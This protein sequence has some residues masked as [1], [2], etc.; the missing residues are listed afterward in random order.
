V[1]LY[2][3]AAETA[4]MGLLGATDAGDGRTAAVVM[5][6]RR[7][8]W[9]VQLSLTWLVRA[10]THRTRSFF[11]LQA[12]PPDGSELWRSDVRLVSHSFE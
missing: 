7:V 3:T 2:G 4:A 8:R 12:W 9:T 10:Q 5:V 1:H 11:M 6:P